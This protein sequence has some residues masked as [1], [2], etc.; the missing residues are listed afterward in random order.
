MYIKKQKLFTRKLIHQCPICNK[1]DLNKPRIQEENIT[2]QHHTVVNS[3][4]LCQTPYVIN[5]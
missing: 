4:C 5:C 2:N 3:T 1:K